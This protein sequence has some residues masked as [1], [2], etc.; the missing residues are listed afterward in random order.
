MTLPLK[1]GN[2]LHEQTN[3][4]EGQ[5]QARLLDSPVMTP[6]HCYPNKYGPHTTAGEQGEILANKSAAMRQPILHIVPICVAH[7]LQL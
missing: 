7:T 6:C 3:K 1:I 2:I 4:G 5:G